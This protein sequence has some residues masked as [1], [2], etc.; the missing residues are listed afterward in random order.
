M[1]ELNRD[2]LT[3]I[4]DRLDFLDIYNFSKTCKRI[5]K[6]IYD[7]DMF[8]LNKLNNV[9]TDFNIGCN[10]DNINCLAKIYYYLSFDLIKGRNK[11]CEKGD[12]KMVKMYSDFNHDDILISIEKQQTEILDFIIPKTFMNDNMLYGYCLRIAIRTNKV[13]V[14]EYFSK[15]T[16]ISDKMINAASQYSNLEI[17]KILLPK[18]Q[19]NFIHTFAVRKTAAEIAGK[20]K[21]DKVAEYLDGYDLPLFSIILMILIGSF[22]YI[23]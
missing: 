8:W 14:V 2:C 11:A 6:V 5:K 18:L 20:Y 15:R 19:T 17:M 3:L 7:N 16:N 22:F 10:F 23:G 21:N 12:L 1:N 13:K 9:D 4:A